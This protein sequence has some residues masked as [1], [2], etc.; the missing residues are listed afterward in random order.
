[1]ES[2]IRLSGLLDGFR[3][4]VDTIWIISID[5]AQV[6]I[7]RD[8]M[9]PEEEGQVLDYKVLSDTY[10]SDYVYPPDVALWNEALSFP[11]LK[12]FSGLPVEVL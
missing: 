12:A 9:M 7:L 10:I 3:H 1:M 5:D 11:A 8:S 2:R 4:I 6:E